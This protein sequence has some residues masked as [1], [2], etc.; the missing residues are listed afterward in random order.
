MSKP[1]KYPATSKAKNRAHIDAG[2]LSINHPHSVDNVTP[3]ATQ[4]DIER[5][6][7]E[8]ARYN[9]NNVN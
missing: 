2:N 7:A 6:L 3:P 4:P 9:V 5:G 1:K 8:D